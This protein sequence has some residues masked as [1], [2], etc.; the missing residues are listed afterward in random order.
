MKLLCGILIFWFLGTVSAYGQYGNEWIDDYSKTFYKIKVVEDGIYRIDYNTLTAYGIPASSI[1]PENFTLHGKEKEQFIYVN[2][3]GDGT[4]DPGD[5]IE[6]FGQRNNGWLDSLLHDN[7]NELGNPDFSLYNDTLVYFLS[8]NNLTNNRRMAV[9]SD[10]NFGSYSS[11]PYI[12]YTVLKSY[13]NQYLQGQ[14]LA[15]LSESTYEQGEGWFSGNANAYSGS[16]YLQTNLSTPQAYTS[17][18]PPAEVY[19]ISASLSNASGIPNHHTQLQY[20][21]GSNYITEIDTVFSGY[22]LNRLSLNIPNN[23]IL[24]TTRIRHNLIP[25][26]GVATD[27]QAISYVRVRY[28]RNLNFS[29]QD[30]FEF[31][32]PYNTTENKSYLQINNFGGSNPLLYILGDSIKR[33]TT[34]NN[35][36]WDALIPNTLNGS[37]QKCLMID[38]TEVRQVTTLE[39]MQ[40]VDYSALSLDSAFIIITHPKLITKA[41]DYAAYRAS[42]NGGSHDTIVVDINQLYMQ[43]GGGIEKHALSIKRF[44][45]HV[46]DVWPTNPAH[47]FLIGK[48]IREA[49]EGGSLGTRKDAANFHQCLVPSFGYP[50]SDVLLTSGL[51]GTEHEPAIPTGRLAANT[52]TEVEDYLNKIIEY[53][54]HQ[55]NPVYSYTNKDWMKHV[56]HFSGGSNSTEQ[57]LFQNYL[58]H[59]GDIVEDTSFAGMDELFAKT[60]SDPIDPVVLSEVT[61]RLQDGVSLM[62]FFGHA[63][64][65]GFDQNLDHPSNWGNQGKYPF[66]IANSC[67]TGDIH[68]PDGISTSEEF[69]LIPNRGV[70]GYLAS[71]KV[72]FSGDLHYYTTELYHQFCQ[73]HYGASM[74]KC[75]QETINHNQ[76]NLQSFA[77]RT[78]AQQ[79]TLHGDP[80]LKINSHERPEYHIDQNSVYFTPQNVTLNTDSLKMHL[81]VTNLGKGRSEDYRVEV[82]RYMPSGEV[83]TL[84][85]TIDKVNDPKH[86]KDTVVFSIPVKHNEAAGINNFEINVDVPSFITEQYEEISNNTL[87]YSLFLDFDGILPIW[88]YKYAIV[89][90]DTIT[91]K[92]STINPFANQNDYI[93]EIDTIDFEG[94]P[95]PFKKYQRINSTG[96]VVNAR[97]QSWLLSSNN[98]PSPLQLTDST[99]YFWRVSLDSSVKVWDERSFQYIQ[100]KRGWGQDHF[101]Q[102]KDNDYSIVKYDRPNRQFKFG[103]FYKTIQCQVFGNANNGYEYNYTYWGID[104]G[105]EEY[106]ICGLT[107]TIHVAVIDPLT[108]EAWKTNYNGN[109]PQWDFGNDLSCTNSRGRSEKFFIFRQNNQTHLDSLE[110]MLQNDIP[111]G[112]YVLLYTSVA[113]KYSWWAATNP[114]LDDLLQSYGGTNISTNNPD[115]T[116]FAFFF[117]KGYPST[118]NEQFTA[119]FNDTIMLND[120]LFSFDFS[121]NILSEQMGPA[122]EW[123]SLHWEQFP[124]ETNTSDSTRIRLFGVDMTG[125]QTLLLDS[126]FTPLDSVL[127]LTTNYGLDASIY[128]YARLQAYVQDT[129]AFTPAQIDRWQILYTPVPEAALNPKKGFHFTVNNDSIHEGK[130]FDLAVAIENI[131]DLDMDSLLV[132]Y[133]IEDK[134][135]NRNY[136]DYPRQDSLRAGDVLLD[137]ISINTAGYSGQNSTW[138]EAN[139]YLNGTKDQLEQYH[140][141]NIGQLAYFSIVD[142]TNPIL[143]VTFDGRHIL[144][145]DIVSGK[146]HIHITLDDE[147]EWLIMDAIEDTAN[148]QVF[149]TNPDGS[150][151]RVYFTE[152][153]VTVLE[154]TPA[155]GSKNEFKIDYRP[156]LT[157]DGEYELLIQ[158]SDKSGNASGDV[159]YRI[160][161]EVVNASTITEVMNYPNP[162]STRTRFVFTLTGNKLPDYMKIQIL[163][164]SG[165]VVREITMDELGPL[166][167][168][169]NITEYYWNGTD[170]FGDRLANGVYLY[171][172][173]TEMGGEGIDKRASGADAYFTKGY[174]KMYLMR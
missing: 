24:G 133:W 125:N 75:I 110:D 56:L 121:G 55:L 130:A 43:Y 91:L 49:K 168:G 173:I 38:E 78:T 46:L 82:K 90:N 95:S 106:G 107:P 149:L 138:I 124:Q 29:N 94:A 105:I 51:N 80:A 109:Y 153:G 141:N 3:G 71:V 45:K 117:R 48:S 10:V 88:P 123:H 102:F 152:G 132:H 154:F 25:D 47:L 83:D 150:Q 156:E 151:D 92:G 101:F 137:T 174:G 165:K 11:V 18:G 157:K 135:R 44:A 155:S 142:I 77:F 166:H 70:I 169:R 112:H 119:H 160:S 39:P 96:G 32:V 14:K 140:Y 74:G 66:M 159:D 126:L 20:Y 144:D 41:R 13:N 34:V 9:E 100:G 26:L 30:Y 148:F 163:T 1:N 89:P 53:E 23:Q 65:N 4:M 17:G 33:V 93:F 98:M 72:G 2:D 15:G 86:Y 73:K 54:D 120:T 158:A 7:P 61:G 147:N 19:A 143:D 35:G 139:P 127:D 162:F 171:R 146:P 76:S 27:Y 67:Y 81:I 59:Y 37:D 60:S 161:F 40:F 167:V 104:G 103:E 136:I 68:Q 99:V 62:T 145:G 87:N 64:V 134:D 170:E 79:M 114:N 57:S 84:N 21:E 50:S 85:R 63:S 116:A 5:Y 108:L 36:T 128:P 113:A 69:V 8:W 118:A 28:P 122:S 58:N 131:S 97:P 115:T 31:E 12:Y 172:V 52:P 164:V 111:N 42:M 22:Q 6:F 16:G 129:S